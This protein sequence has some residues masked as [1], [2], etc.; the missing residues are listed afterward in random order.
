MREHIDLT[1]M[2]EKLQSSSLNCGG[3]WKV[4]I[5]EKEVLQE[6]VKDALIRIFHENPKFDEL[7]KY[8]EFQKRGEW[9]PFEQ[10]LTRNIKLIE[11]IDWEKYLN[12]RIDYWS[13]FELI[14]KEEMKLDLYEYNK[15]EFIQYLTQELYKESD[16]LKCFRLD[17]ST[18]DTY[19]LWWH[20][21]QEDLVFDIKNSLIVLNFGWSS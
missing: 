15:Q 8:E 3:M 2:I 7:E 17:D 14:S 5:I 1:E 11:I 6:E 10:K 4:R 18:F 9:N 20:Q 21:I 13:E 19:E 12:E 16:N